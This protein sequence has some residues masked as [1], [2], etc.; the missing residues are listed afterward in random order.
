VLPR[1]PTEPGP[2]SC[3]PAGGCAES[4]TGTPLEARARLTGE[5]LALPYAPKDS[6]AGMPNS[7][8]LI[9]FWRSSE[10]QKA[11]VGARQVARRLWRPAGARRLSAQL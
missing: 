10:F 3:A 1:R 7:G 9:D 5:H 8:A 4:L 11:D 2:P 6:K